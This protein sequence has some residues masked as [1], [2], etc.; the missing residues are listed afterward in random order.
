[1]A[2]PRVTK[3]RLES[4]R[5]KL[6]E[7]GGSAGNT[8]LCG[9]LGWESALYWRVRERLLNEGVVQKGRGRGGS[10][11]LTKVEE[12][13]EQPEYQAEK[14]LYDPASK[15]IQDPFLSDLDLATM[16]D[17]NSL[18]EITANQGGKKTAG[19]WTRPDITA[20]VVRKFKHQP[21]KALDV[22]TFEVKA[23]DGLAI[24]AVYEALSHSKVATFAYLLIYIPSED[25]DAHPDRPRVEEACT[26]HGIGLI[27]AADIASFSE[28]ETRIAAKR[29]TPDPGETDRFIDV[30]LSKSNKDKIANWL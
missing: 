8:Y 5:S 3:G 14:D 26:M 28:W 20:V 15:V 1:M 16:G 13:E 25:F 23:K 27:I 10:V 7:L 9:Q 17:R 21:V 11:S 2:T 30:Q 22:L 18:V 19:K 6:E 29:L 4:F 24:D 12:A